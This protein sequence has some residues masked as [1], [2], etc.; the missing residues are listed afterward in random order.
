MR[1]LNLYPHL[2]FLISQRMFKVITSSNFA[3]RFNTN[4]ERGKQRQNELLGKYRDRFH[5]ITADEKHLRLATP[6]G[7]IIINPYFVSHENIIN[8]AYQI[9]TPQHHLI[10]TSDLDHVF[11]SAN[12]PNRDLS[13]PMEYSADGKPMMMK[14]P[15]DLM[16]VEANYDRD[17]LEEALREDPDNAHAR[18]NLRHISEQ[19]TWQYIQY[20]LAPHGLF[21]PLH[22]SSA[23]GTLVQDLE[24]EKPE[25]ATNSNNTNTQA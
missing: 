1:L 5:L 9:D 17:I 7:V 4:K 13:L 11:T 12:D 22:A 21:V 14:R 24:P 16:F 8:V 15:F 6:N 20:T 2:R 3:H 19:E 25:P 23:F 10:Y 18:G